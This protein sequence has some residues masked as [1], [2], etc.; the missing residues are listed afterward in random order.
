MVRDI[1]EKSDGF[2]LMNSD[3]IY[4]PGFISLVVKQAD[5]VSAV[6][7]RGR[8]LGS[9]DMK[10]T[11]EGTRLISISK[12]LHSYTHGY[13]GVTLVKKSGLSDYIASLDLILRKKNW[14]SYCAEDVLQNMAAGGKNPLVLDVG[15]VEWYEI[16][17]PEEL[18]RAENE[19]GYI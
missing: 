18:R 6:C 14:K 11:A 15:R 13:I 2:I 4:P 3:H 5:Y 8:S 10:V 12:R 7:D 9:D 16:D 1:I 19:A 17:S